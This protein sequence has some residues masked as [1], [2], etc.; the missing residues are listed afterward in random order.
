MTDITYP[1]HE[2]VPPHLYQP[3]NEYDLASLTR[4]ERVY[5][6][7]MRTADEGARD[8]AE[9][10]A[11]VISRCILDK[12]R[13][14]VG[15]GAGRCALK[16]YDELVKL[17][18]ADKVN[19]ADVIFFNIGEL[20]LG[21]STES[22]NTMSRLR[23]HLFNKIDVPEENIHTFNSNATQDNVHKFCKAY[24]SEIA[25]QGGLDL[26]VCE[27]TRTASLAFNEPGA[28]S[29]SKCRLVLLS[30]ETRRR[31]SEAFQRDTAPATALTLG[32]GN[33]LQ[34]HHVICV[35]WGV[36]SSKPLFDAIEGRMGEHA[37]ASYLQMHDNVKIIAD[38]EAA[39]RLTRIRYPWRVTSCQ[40]NDKL[41]RRAIVWLSD[42]TGKPVLKLTDV[43]YNDHGLGDL[44]A[45]FESAYNVNIK[46]FNDLQHT[47]TGWP[48]GKPN[49]D[50]TNRPETALPYP[51]RVLIFSPHPDDVVVSMGGTLQRLVSQKHD[52]HVAFQTNGD[53]AVADEDLERTM[54]LVGKM[55]Q[56]FGTAASIDGEIHT[57]IDEIHNR[58]KDSAPSANI[59]FIKGAIFTCEGYMSCQSL[60]VKRE[61]IHEL[62]MPFYQQSPTGIGHLSDADVA[63]VEQLIRQVKPHRI[64]VADDLND[65]YG[66]HEPATRSVLIAL[67]DL[68]DEPFMQ[69]CR[70]W[71]YRGQWDLWNVDHVEMAVPMSPEEF[72]LKLD[73]IIKHQSQ[74]HDAP[75]RNTPEGKLSW[76]RTIER[77]RALADHYNRLGLAAYE[78]IEAFVRYL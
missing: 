10:I 18:F 41:I 50:D 24:E 11:H 55:A 35:A 21:E 32:I 42:I 62:S 52:V 67:E 59:R 9:D 72:A 25:E 13:C 63:I 66:T 61:N 51:K 40:W 43:D 44:V 33:L 56:H 12:G 77:N 64:F 68:K 15:L 37:P 48:G 28:T 2:N 14:V 47:I 7:V 73:A 29:S 46:I 45:Q 23:S 60:G 30:G 22:G 19:F 78:A 76:Q 20:G 5:T 70:V 69:Q 34:A 49:A 75:L 31:V 38:L 74:V 54:M 3:E 8:A 57:L 26:L 1:C 17:Y 65:P 4:Y 27:L 36:D 39:E 16:V 71:L 53:V 58:D 6:K